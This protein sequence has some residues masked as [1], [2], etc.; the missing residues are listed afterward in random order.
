MVLQLSEA[1]N[2]IQPDMLDWLAKETAWLV[3]ANY[4]FFPPTHLGVSHTTT[5]GPHG[6]GTYL[7]TNY[8]FYHSREGT[9]LDQQDWTDER[10]VTNHPVWS[11]CRPSPATTLDAVIL[12]GACTRHGI[13]KDQQQHSNKTRMTSS[14]F[15][16]ANATKS[17]FVYSEDSNR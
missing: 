6:K 2:F 16:I 7:T 17:V 15:R 3:L 4:N 13:P 1:H 10:A 5:W 11:T 14:S 8:H 9:S 12:W